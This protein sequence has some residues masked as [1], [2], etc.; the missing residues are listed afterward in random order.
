MMTKLS[1]F[2]SKLRRDER[3]LTTVEYAIVLV[4]IA[5]AGVAVWN[6]FGTTVKDKLQDSNDHIESELDTDF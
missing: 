1:H 4:L 2:L 3:G 5:A 6:E